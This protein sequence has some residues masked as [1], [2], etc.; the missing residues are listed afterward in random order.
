MLNNHSFQDTGF[1]PINLSRGEMFCGHIEW[2]QVSSKQA[3]IIDCQ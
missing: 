2:G 1:V 3:S